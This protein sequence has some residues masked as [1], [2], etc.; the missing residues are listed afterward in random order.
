MSMYVLEGSSEIIN[1]ERNSRGCPVL[2]PE[3]Y[4]ENFGKTKDLARANCIL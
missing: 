3:R 2:T 4:F 1:R